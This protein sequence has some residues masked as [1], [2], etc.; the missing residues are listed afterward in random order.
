M[1]LSEPTYATP[2]ETIRDSLCPF[3]S[4]AGLPSIPGSG[5]IPLPSGILLNFKGGGVP[6]E[7]VAGKFVPQAGRQH[8]K[9]SR[10]RH[11]TIYP[12]LAN[13]YIAFSR[14]EIAKQTNEAISSERRGQAAKSS[15]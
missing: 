2:L 14:D 15:C 13:V 5:S 6:D 11:E 8:S 4:G 12:F 1:P 10:A 3:G 7:V 9:R